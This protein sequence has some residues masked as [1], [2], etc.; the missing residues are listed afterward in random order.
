MAEF[1]R[2]L[3]AHLLFGEK[4]VRNHHTTSS[5]TT[6]QTPVLDVKKF[7]NVDRDDMEWF[8]DN[9][10]M[11]G[12]DFIHTFYPTEKRPRFESLVVRDDAAK[13]DAQA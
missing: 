7:D 3:A 12:D 1:A 2:C 8:F 4:A 10:V 9:M 13:V 5:T 11:D 6:Q